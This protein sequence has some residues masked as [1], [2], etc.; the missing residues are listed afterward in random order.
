VI[1]SKLNA[2]HRTW[3]KIFARTGYAARGLIYTVIGIFAILAAVDAGRETTGS[4]GALQTLMSSGFGDF[5]AVALLC[6]TVSYMVWRSVQSLFDTDGHGLGAKGAAIRGG[7][8]ASAVTYAIL[9]AYIFGLWRGGSGG[10]DGGSSLGDA[11]TSG[12]AGVVGSQFVALALTATF[13]GV[14]I[15]HV[16]KA[17]RKGYARHFEASERVMRFVHPTARTGLTARGLV[18]LVIAFLFFYRGLNAGED[19][20]STPGVEDVLGFL[21]ELPAGGILLGLMGTGLIAF[22]LYSFLQALWRRINVEDAD[23]IG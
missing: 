13:A 5:I 8:L 1:A 4:R 16:V 15:A 6:G 14:G 17:A 10:E 18:F 7:L 9:T 3:F 11:I 21:Q 2:R 22:A 20:S 19:G 12:I 23:S